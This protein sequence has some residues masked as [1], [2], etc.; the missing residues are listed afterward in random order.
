MTP[1]CYLYAIVS[2]WGISHITYWGIKAKAPACLFIN[3]MDSNGPMGPFQV[4]I[5]W[6]KWQLKY[7]NLNSSFNGV[8]V[9]LLHYWFSQHKCTLCKH[10][11]R[12]YCTCILW[13]HTTFSQDISLL[14]KYLVRYTQKSIYNPNMTLEMNTQYLYS[15]STSH[16]VPSKSIT[17]TK[18]IHKEL[19]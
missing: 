1:V 5:S 17:D 10:C 2:Q 18:Y 4:F 12:P 19:N 8:H 15:W 11:I 13:I 7:M 9:M 14:D 6:W 16:H 3:L